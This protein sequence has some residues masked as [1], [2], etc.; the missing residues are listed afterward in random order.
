MIGPLGGGASSMMSRTW[1]VGANAMSPVGVE[2]GS[3][4]SARS[5][6]GSGLRIQPG[7][8]SA[9]HAPSFDHDRFDPVARG[10]TQ[11]LP[12]KLRDGRHPTHALMDTTRTSG[13]R[14]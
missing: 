14:A 7:G 1:M 11:D 12:A 5:V 6:I 2:S 13:E 9:S 4:S 8:S 10:T 3:R